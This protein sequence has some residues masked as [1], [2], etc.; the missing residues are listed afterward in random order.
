MTFADLM[1][2]L[3]CFFVLLLSFSEMDAAKY[4]EVAGSMKFAFGVQRQVKVSERVKGTSVIAKEY[5]PG[6]PTPTPIKIMRQQTT[7]ETKNSIEFTNKEIQKAKQQADALE[8][9]FKKELGEG[10]LEIERHNNE[11]TI[12]IRERGSFPSGSATL[13]ASF[14]P[15]LAKIGKA[16][17]E[18]GGSLVVSGHTDNVPINT[19]LYASNWVLSSAR[20]ATV[21]HH[22]TMRSKVASERMEIRAH[23]DTQPVAAND[24]A[25]GR[26][27][28]RRV[29]I[30]IVHRRSKGDASA[31]EATQAGPE[32]IWKTP[33]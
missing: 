18:T 22:L 3:M 1:S 5:S 30:T 14:L 6:R 24:S 21:V 19:A 4:K 2:L 26:S 33:P 9:M 17:N 8:E 27:K 23:A 12:R 20:A 31:P 32:V 29:E 25:A 15:V 10:L 28:N 16:L 11:V 13:A 7:D